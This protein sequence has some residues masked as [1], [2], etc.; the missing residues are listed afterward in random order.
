[1]GY[2]DPEGE[3]FIT[4]RKKDLIIRGGENISPGAV[5]DVL[6]KH[7]AVLETA[8]VGIPDPVYG[9]EVKALVVL[10]QGFQ[11]SEKELLEH[12]LKHIPRFKAP[13]SVGFLKEL[14]KN[15]V[16]KVLKRTLRDMEKK[17]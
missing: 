3:L 10:K 15:S 13:K 14:P 2:L 5:E 8:V 9:E 11:A 16:G 7:P 6:F 1:V 17:K 4:D 12:C